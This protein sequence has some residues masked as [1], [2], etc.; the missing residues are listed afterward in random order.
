M[1]KLYKNKHKNILQ[2][3]TKIVLTSCLGCETVLSLFS[4]G[5]YK[6]QDFTEFLGRNIDLKI[7]Q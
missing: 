1:L 2:T 7:N 6:V 4:L 3:K 5:K